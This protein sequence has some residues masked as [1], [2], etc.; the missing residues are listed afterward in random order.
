MIEQTGGRLPIKEAA[1]ELGVSIDT[2]RRHLRNGKLHGEFRGGKWE[3][4]LATAQRRP[5]Q[6]H[7]QSD[8]TL[9]DRVTR[10][11]A[12]VDELSGLIRAM[13][14]TPAGRG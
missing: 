8:V 2:V 7:G 1:Q 12:R 11:E 14:G 5:G 4:E 10:L 13:L 6:L 3:V 9:A